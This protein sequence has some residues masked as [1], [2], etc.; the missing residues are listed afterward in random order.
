MTHRNGISRNAYPN[1]T[2]VRTLVQR[3]LQELGWD[4]PD[5]VCNEY[6]LKLK[7]TTRRIECPTRSS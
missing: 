3:I 1:E 5:K 2:A 7:T 4:D 6:P